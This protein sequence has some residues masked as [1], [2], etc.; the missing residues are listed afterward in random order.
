MS[1]IS[2]GNLESLFRAQVWDEDANTQ[3]VSADAAVVGC[4]VRSLRDARARFLPP[5]G[6]S[7]NPLPSGD[8]FQRSFSRQKRGVSN[9]E[10]WV[11]ENDV[12]VLGEIAEKGSQSYRVRPL[13]CSRRHPASGVKSVAKIGV[14]KA[15]NEPSKVWKILGKLMQIVRSKAFCCRALALST[16]ACK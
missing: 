10:V 4:H 11:K 7:C 5:F 1:S 14:S 8:I 15:E 16:L 2:I 9:A 6:A 3:T 13:K 12:W